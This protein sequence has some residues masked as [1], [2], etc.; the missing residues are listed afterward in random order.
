M[1]NVKIQTH[2]IKAETEISNYVLCMNT[3]TKEGFMICTDDED[4]SLAADFETFT[5]TAFSG[6][7]RLHVSYDN[8]EDTNQSYFKLCSCIRGK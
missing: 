4:L 7:L 2:T 8:F 3:A 6:T 5:I 1:S